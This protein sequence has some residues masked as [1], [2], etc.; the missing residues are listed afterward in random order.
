MSGPAWLLSFNTPS[1]ADMAERLADVQRATE[2]LLAELGAPVS[3]LATIRIRCDGC[4][5]SGPDAA[6]PTDA[7]AAAAGLGWQ[8]NA[9]G[10]DLCPECAR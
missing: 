2:A 7:L 3:L 4:D 1:N 6:T 10:T 9:A 5:A 8:H